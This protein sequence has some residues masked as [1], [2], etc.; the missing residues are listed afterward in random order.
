MKKDKLPSAEY[1]RFSGKYAAGYTG[2]LLALRFLLALFP[3]AQVCVLGN[4]LNCAQQA[5]TKQKITGELMQSMAL[6]IGL[7]LLNAVL[8]MINGYVKMKYGI[9]TGIAYDRTLLEKRSRLRYDLTEDQDAQELVSRLSEESTGRIA[10]GLQNILD[11]G[12]F[13]VRIISIAVVVMT[14]NVWIGLAVIAIFV[15]LLPVAKKCGEEDYDAYEMADKQ[16]RRAS[17]L[18]LMLYH[19]DYAD[20]RKLFG[21][22]A[23]VNE[24]WEEQYDEGRKISKRATRHNFVRIK[25]AGLLVDFLALGMAALLLF[26]VRE[27]A[28]EA[29]TYV[30]LVGAILGITKLMS[31][32]MSYLIEDFISNKEYIRDFLCFMELLEE[33][34]AE[35][36]SKQTAERVDSIEFDRVSFRYP[37]C[38][39]YVLREMSFKMERGKTYAFVGENGAGKTTITKLLLG[40]YREYEGVIRINGRDIRHMGTEELFRF[41]SVAYQDFPRYEATLRENLILGRAQERQVSEQEIRECLKLLGMEEYVN[42]LPEGLDTEIGRLSEEGKD[43]SGGQWQRIAIARA[44]LAKAPILIMDEPTASLDPLHE[45]DIFK[46]LLQEERSDLRIL[47]THRLGGISGADRIFVIA[48]GAV[49]ECGSHAELV[50]MA[51]MYADMFEKQGRWYR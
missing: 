13:G 31:W 50:A 30:A 9:R 40:L 8:G 10:G 19:R 41:F 3:A 44:L 46:L 29:G 6:L 17:Y 38:E 14:S 2:V 7:I 22:T 11:L 49:K 35:G 18:Q 39:Q 51:G 28:M 23:P 37:G 45:R 21:Y 36:A 47:I 42:G 25:G 48:D 20:E 27:G 24:K 43:L 26:P 4:F 16:F 32:N 5:F 15:L 34:A 12:E 1:L 33:C